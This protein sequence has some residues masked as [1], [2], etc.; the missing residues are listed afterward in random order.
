M[1]RAFDDDGGA[2]GYGQQRAPKS[3][4]L[5]KYLISFALAALVFYFLKQSDIKQTCSVSC[6]P[7][8]LLQNQSGGR[9]MKKAWSMIRP[10]SVHFYFGSSPC[11]D[12]YQPH[13]LSCFNSYHSRELVVSTKLKFPLEK[14]TCI[15][16]P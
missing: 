15:K 2:L 6:R 10:H 14:L 1:L 12:D 7:I 16:R 13:Q 11:R 8:F 9:G 3:H 4:P 5:Q